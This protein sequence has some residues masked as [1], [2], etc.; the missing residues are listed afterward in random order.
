MSSWTMQKGGL[1]STVVNKYCIFNPIQTG[2]F[3]RF[4]QQVGGFRGPP[5]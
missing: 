4:L 3:F 2:L 5:L 1:Q